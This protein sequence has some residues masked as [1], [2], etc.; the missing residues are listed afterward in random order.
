MNKLDLAQTTIDPEILDELSRDE[1]SGVRW[2]VAENPNTSPE[3]LDYLSK[4]KDW[5]V[6]Y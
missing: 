3:T 1:D 6:R 2:R 4:D 5:L